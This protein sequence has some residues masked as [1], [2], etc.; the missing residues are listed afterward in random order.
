MNQ[1]PVKDILI[2]KFLDVKKTLDASKSYLIFENDLK[3]TSD[4]ILSESLPVYQYLDKHQFHW[5]KIFDKQ[6]DREYLIVQTEPGK[7][8]NILGRLISC[9]L[10]KDMVYYVYKATS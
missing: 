10:P 6:L 1:K 9:Q 3:R 4:S 8:D 5:Q 2:K 7:E